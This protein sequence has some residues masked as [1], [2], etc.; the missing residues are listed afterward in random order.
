[1]C[2]AYCGGYAK[3]AAMKLVRAEK[4]AGTNDDDSPLTEKIDVFA[5][6]YMLKRTKLSQ[7][8]ISFLAWTEFAASNFEIVEAGYDNRNSQFQ[9]MNLDIISNICRT[10]SIFIWNLAHL[11]Y[12]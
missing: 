8:K 10:V 9:R 6:E 7:N 2:E 1:M 5:W 11:T 12:I 3:G 4:W